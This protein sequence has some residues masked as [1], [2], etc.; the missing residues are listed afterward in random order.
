MNSENTH[1]NYLCRELSLEFFTV[2]TMLS[3]F[4]VEPGISVSDLS[5]RR[6][7]MIFLEQEEL[8]KLIVVRLTA[9]SPQARESWFFDI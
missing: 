2:L 4:V 5:H 3:N 8:E 9:G 6:E 7:P 1:K